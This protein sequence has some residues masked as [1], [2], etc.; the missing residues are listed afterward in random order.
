MDKQQTYNLYSEV[1][2]KLNAE[3]Q[4]TKKA[5]DRLYS[6]LIATI[7]KKRRLRTEILVYRHKEYMSA[8]NKT[9]FN[10][11]SQT[12]IINKIGDVVDNYVSTDMTI[13]EAETYEYYVTVEYTDTDGNT[14]SKNILPSKIFLYIEPESINPNDYEF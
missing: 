9:A 1:Y 7:L 2:N 8:G 10:I 13:S 5:C 6:E 3:L 12:Y 11:R 14:R 4:E